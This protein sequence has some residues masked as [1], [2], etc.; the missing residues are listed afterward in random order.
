MN[1]VEISAIGSTKLRKFKKFWIYELNCKG[2]KVCTEI[3]T[4]AGQY[5]TYKSVE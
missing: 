1:S 4:K 3:V 2:D 5:R